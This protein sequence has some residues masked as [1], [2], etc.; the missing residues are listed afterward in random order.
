M[1]AKS[2]ESRY[3]RNPP[4]RGFSDP[5]TDGHPC[6]MTKFEDTVMGE[7]LAESSHC[8]FL[9]DQIAEYLP[10]KRIYFLNCGSEEMKFSYFPN[11]Q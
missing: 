7:P 9:F 11:S 3:M 10:N 6:D 2:P 8:V 1:T 4:T 5:Q